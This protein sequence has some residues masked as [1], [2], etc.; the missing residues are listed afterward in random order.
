MTT[1][2]AG[3]W[4]QRDGRTGQ[5]VTGGEAHVTK[6]ERISY[7]YDRAFYG[8]DYTSIRNSTT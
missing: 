2:V 1:A 6:I 4:N 3:V 5:F 7:A 8:F